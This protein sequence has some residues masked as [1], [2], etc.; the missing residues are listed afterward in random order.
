MESKNIH[1][2]KKSDHNPNNIDTDS[3]DENPQKQVK[4]QKKLENSSNN[5]NHEN[6]KNENLN[7]NGQESTTNNINKDTEYEIN[8]LESHRQELNPKIEFSENQKNEPIQP[9]T[10]ITGMISP[11]SMANEIEGNVPACY[12]FGYRAYNKSIFFTIFSNFF[13]FLKLLFFT[14]GTI[15]N[16]HK[17][18][19]PNVFFIL[20]FALFALTQIIKIID[21]MNISLR[22]DRF[23]M[24]EILI[25]IYM[26]VFYLLFTIGF[27]FDFGWVM[28]ILVPL[29]F[30]NC[31]LITMVQCMLY[32]LNSSKLQI[33]RRERNR[34][35]TS[36]LCGRLSLVFMWL[37]LSLKVFGVIG[38]WYYIS[39]PVAVYC[40]IKGFLSVFVSFFTCCYAMPLAS[41]MYFLIALVF[42]SIAGLCIMVP[43]F[44]KDGSYRWA[45]AIFTIILCF[46]GTVILMLRTLITCSRSKK[47]YR[48][49]LLKLNPTLRFK[50]I[51][52]MEIKKKKY[53]IQKHQKNKKQNKNDKKNEKGRFNG[54]YFADMVGME[55]AEDN[56]ADLQN[57]KSEIECC[58]YCQ[59]NQP[60]ACFFPCKHGGVCRDCAIACTDMRVECPIC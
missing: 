6:E 51:K 3:E 53:S 32:E 23:L 40:I 9:Q 35:F 41:F 43:F 60:E 21:K 15:T 57:S 14:L 13:W 46:V 19:S 16:K 20:V 58:Y 22:N 26:F 12:L 8:T 50:D 37:V 29:P 10:I 18:D 1:N 47:R 17:Q 38:H 24:P 39:I 42:W 52:K 7:I 30:F 31:G 49:D 59:N 33:E 44:E 56:I 54:A 48:K 28:F 11:Y 5:K 34:R 36:F 27:I 55:D 45:M 2:L 4:V 25:E